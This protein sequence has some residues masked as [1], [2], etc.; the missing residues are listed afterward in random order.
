MTF[1]IYDSKGKVKRNRVCI[2]CQKAIED[3]ETVLVEQNHK[4]EVD[5]NQIIKRHG[6]DLVTKVG[7]MRSQ[8]YQF[9]DVTGN[10]FQEAANILIKAQDQFDSLPSAVRKE[11]DHNPAKFL[12]F[13]QNPDNLPKMY[14]MGLAVK[15]APEQPVQVLVTNPEPVPETPAE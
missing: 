12:D 13:V 1:A 6:I 8:E 3:G 9:D 15:P 2:D 10:D 7:M 4:D 11:F 5:I 14:E